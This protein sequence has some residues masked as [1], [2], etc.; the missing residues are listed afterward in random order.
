MAALINQI[1]AR[2]IND[3]YAFDGET[4]EIISKLPP[5]SLRVADLVLDVLF[6]RQIV[7]C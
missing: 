1:Q 2:T 6:S 7:A 5:V 3:E 4:R